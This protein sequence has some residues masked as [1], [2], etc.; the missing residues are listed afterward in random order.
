MLIIFYNILARAGA[1]GLAQGGFSVMRG[2]DFW[3]GAAAGFV[4]S[5]AGS[6]AQRIGIHGWGM[7]GVSAFSGGAGAAIAGGKTEDI[8]FG[9]VCGAMVGALNHG[10]GEK[11]QKKEIE[12]AKLEL[13][14][15][16]KLHGFVESSFEIT[17]KIVKGLPSISVILRGG[18][19]LASL[20]AALKDFKSAL[21]P[22]GFTLNEI[23]DLGKL[24]T[25]DYNGKDFMLSSAINFA[26]TKIPAVAVAMVFIQ[27]IST[28]PVPAYYQNPVCPKD[29]TIHVI[30]HYT[31]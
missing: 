22:I 28:D 20:G 17:S 19:S 13:E 8:L 6:G 16:L 25:G 3:Q 7:V 21:G 27:I 14:S 1:H 4:S 31:H 23:S 18:G 9:V 11:Q 10:A 26:A 24:S 30:Q 12:K 5:L 29:N 2:G 15:L